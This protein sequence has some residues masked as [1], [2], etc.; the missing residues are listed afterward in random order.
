[1][2]TSWYS[3]CQEIEPYKNYFESISDCDFHCLEDL[4]ID[5]LLISVP[6]RTC[7]PISDGEC[8]LRNV[9]SIKYVKNNELE[10]ALYLL[11]SGKISLY[12]I[13]QILSVSEKF[14]HIDNLESAILDIYKQFDKERLV[15]WKKSL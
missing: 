4:S 10:N 1:M 3:L 14:N 13:L 2:T 12:E 5:D 15:V 9:G 6:H 8:Y 7:Q 11:S